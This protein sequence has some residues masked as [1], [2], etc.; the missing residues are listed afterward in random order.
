MI[1]DD[2][3]TFGRTTSSIT[4]FS[5]TIKNMTLSIDAIDAGS[6][7]TKYIRGND[8]KLNDT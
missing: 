6:C 3:T 4:T 1:S 8:T 2:A 7:C 5:I